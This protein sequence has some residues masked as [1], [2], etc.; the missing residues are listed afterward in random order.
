MVALLLGGLISVSLLAALLMWRALLAM[1]HGNSLVT[2]TDLI[3]QVGSLRLPC[4]SRERG[5][6]RLTVRGSL[7]EVPAYSSAGA[8]RRG[9]TVMV[10]EQRGGDVWVTPHGPS[11][12]S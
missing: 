6:V 2:S 12:T 4:G 8:L 10:L 7:I 5:L 9:Q 11:R 3:G 1:R